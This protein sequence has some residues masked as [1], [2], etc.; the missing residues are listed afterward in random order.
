MSIAELSAVS[1]AA[2]I[3]KI[4]GLSKQFGGMTVID[5]LA[6]DIRRG[7]IFTLLGPSGC[8]KTT[9]LRIIA[10]LERPDSGEVTFEDGSWVSVSHGIFVPPQKRKIGMVFQSY[11]IWPHMTVFENVAYPLRVQGKSTQRVGDILELVHLTDFA[12]RPAPALS[13]GQQQRV[14]L[15]RALACDPELLLL[16]EPFSNLDVHLRQSLRFE[17]KRIQRSLGLTILLVTHDQVDAFSLS[18]RIGVMRKGRFEQ[19]DDGLNLYERPLTS[20]VRDFIGKSLTL[21]GEVTGLTTEQVRVRLACGATLMMPATSADPDIATGADVV[22]SVRYED[23]LVER[24][25]AAEE[26]GISGIVAAVLFLGDHY[27][28]EITLSDN[29]TI[30]ASVPR[31]MKLAEREAVSIRIDPGHAR[32]WS[33]R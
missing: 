15:A 27:E 1:T 19:V 29:T 22:V 14:A 25:A 8:G 31:S 17:L 23:V 4:R 2:T 9:T 5:N 26:C 21:R 10:G 32:V 30:T 18:D 3:L 6:L 24:G 28:C 12:D 7:E 20:Y 13:G 11:A 33:A 16:D